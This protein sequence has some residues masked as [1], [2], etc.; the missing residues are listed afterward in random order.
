MTNKKI[1]KKKKRRNKKKRFQFKLSNVEL[2]I[3]IYS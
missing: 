3:T 2:I 1:I